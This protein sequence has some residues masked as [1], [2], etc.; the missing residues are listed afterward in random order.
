MV[1]ILAIDPSS[2][3]AGICSNER[4]VTWRM[5]GEDRTARLADFHARLKAELSAAEDGGAPYDIVVYERPFARGK[6]ATRCLWGVAGIIEALGH[7]AGA[8][9]LDIPNQ[10]LKKW[11]GVGN[12]KNKEGMIAAMEARTGFRGLNEHEADALALREYVIEVMVVVAATE[13]KK[14]SQ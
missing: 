14:G 9:V 8:A 1:K 6:D 7:L 13:Q 10:T 12:L 11:A 2:T 3:D 5:H 4:P